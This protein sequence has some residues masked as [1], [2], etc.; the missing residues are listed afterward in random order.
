MTSWRFLPR[1][2]EASAVLDLGSL[3]TGISYLSW[4]WLGS[5]RQ[6]GLYKLLFVLQ[7]VSVQ[8]PKRGPPDGLLEGSWPGPRLW[9][10]ARPLRVSLGSWRGFGI[11]GALLSHP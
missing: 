11:A 5:G 7:V 8:S 4:P 6:H 3:R 9:Q 2:P 10:A 1:R